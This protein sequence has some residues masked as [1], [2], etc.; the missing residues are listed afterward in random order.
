MKFRQ[1]LLRLLHNRLGVA[2]P[3]DLP[4]PAYPTFMALFLKVSDSFCEVNAPPFKTAM[5]LRIARQKQKRP[6]QFGKVALN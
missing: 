3:K 1:L 6:C 4:E 5:V 2:R